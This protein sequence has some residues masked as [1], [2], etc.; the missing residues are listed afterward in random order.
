M[1]WEVYK[2]RDMM[3]HFYGFVSVGRGQGSV[4]GWNI[5]IERETDRAM[6]V[7]DTETR[8]TVWLPKS[9]VAPSGELTGF[10]VRKVRDAGFRAIAFYGDVI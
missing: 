3:N 7:R 10:A 9:T 6:L 2:L 4:M 5:R 1:A 8:K